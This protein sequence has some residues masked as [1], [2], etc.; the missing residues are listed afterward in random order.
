MNLR[1]HAAVGGLQRAITQARPVA[2][3]GLLAG[4]CTLH[5]DAVVDGLGLGAVGEPFQVGP[6]AC[7]ACQV[8]REVHAEPGAVGRGVDKARERRAAGEC[9]VGALGKPL[10]RHVLRCQAVH[11]AR[12]A[13]CVQASGIDDDARRQLE[14][15]GRG[16]DLHHRRP[17]AIE[18]NRDHARLHGHRAAMRFDVALQREHQAV[19]VDDARAR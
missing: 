4:R 5:V 18:V 3:D 10:V 6:E 2:P 16:L 19:A 12:H 1:A 11:A 17:S 7:L 8:E 9:E 14:R 13:A 15:A